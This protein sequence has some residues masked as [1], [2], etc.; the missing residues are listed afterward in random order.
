MSVAPPSLDPEDLF[1]DFIYTS[2]KTDVGNILR[3][4]DRQSLGCIYQTSESVN[5]RLNEHC[6]ALVVGDSRTG[7][8][9]E[10]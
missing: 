9:W 6:S 4:L 10:P 3:F 5:D 8:G 2:A 7:S 1:V